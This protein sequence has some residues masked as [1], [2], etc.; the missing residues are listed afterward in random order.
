IADLPSSHRAVVV[1]FYIEELPLDE[2]ARILDLPVGTV[3]S[4][5]HYARE[6][7]RE[8]LIQRQRPVPELQYEFT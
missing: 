1:L 8:A 5:L 4:R 6:R 2:I 3:K 7:L